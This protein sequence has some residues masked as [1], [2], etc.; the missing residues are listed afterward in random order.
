VSLQNRGSY[1][2]QQSVVRLLLENNVDPDIINKE[3][4]YAVDLLPPD[5]SCVLLLQRTMEKEGKLL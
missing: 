3:G 2:S 5:S 4:L 1:K